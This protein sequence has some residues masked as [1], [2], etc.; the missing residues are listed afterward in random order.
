MSTRQALLDGE[1]EL[2]MGVD[3][4]SEAS[5]ASAARLPQSRNANRSGR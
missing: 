2:L 3:R 5:I 4:T 1:I